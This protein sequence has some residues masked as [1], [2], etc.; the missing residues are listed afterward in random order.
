MIPSPYSR[1]AS[2]PEGA[3]RSRSNSGTRSPRQVNRPVRALSPPSSP[4]GSAGLEPASPRLPLSPKSQAEA[5]AAATAATSPSSMN[6]G[7]KSV[8]NNSLRG[9]ACVGVSN[10]PGRSPN[11]G[12]GQQE[13]DSFSP[14]V[15]EQDLLMSVSNLIDH[16][17]SHPDGKSAKTASTRAASASSSIGSSSVR[18]PNLPLQGSS[19]LALDEETLRNV[20]LF[21]RMLQQS[22][23]DLA[24]E[25]DHILQALSSD[26][27]ST[28]VTSLTMKK[29]TCQALEAYVGVISGRRMGPSP[30]TGLRLST[31]ASPAAGTF[32]GSTSRQIS[33]RSAKSSPAKIQSAR[34]PQ[35]DR[36]PEGATTKA[37]AVVVAP[38]AKS[39]AQSDVFSFLGRFVDAVSGSLTPQ[40]EEPSVPT[41]AKEVSGCVDSAGGHPPAVANQDS[42]IAGFRSVSDDSMERF[43]PSPRSAYGEGVCDAVSEDSMVR[44]H[45]V[46]NDPLILQTDSM[47]HELLVQEDSGVA[48]ARS[49]LSE[50]DEGTA[51]LVQTES[52]MPTSPPRSP[53]GGR[54]AVSSWNSGIGMA[55]SDDELLVPTLSDA[56][57]DQEPSM[58][59]NETEEMYRDKE[60]SVSDRGIVVDDKLAIEVVEVLPAETF[61]SNDL[62]TVALSV[63]GHY[64]DKVAASRDKKTKKLASRQES[65]TIVF[66]DPIQALRFEQQR[67]NDEPEHEP[68]VELCE[69]ISSIE[70][71][72]SQHSTDLSS[73]APAVAAAKAAMEASSTTP[74]RQKVDPPSV[75]TAGSDRSDPPTLRSPRM[76]DV[77]LTHLPRSFEEE[78]APLLKVEVKSPSNESLPA[79][80]FTPRRDPDI[81][82]E[83]PLIDTT[84]ELNPRLRTPTAPSQVDVE[85]E[86]KGDLSP[87]VGPTGDRILAD[88]S[89]IPSWNSPPS[90]ASSIDRGSV[91][92]IFFDKTKTRRKRTKKSTGIAQLPS[93][94][95]NGTG[96]QHVH[97]HVS[98]GIRIPPQPESPISVDGHHDLHRAPP[99]SPVSD[100][101]E[102]DHT[103]AMPHLDVISGSIMGRGAS[104][105]VLEPIAETPTLETSPAPTLSAGTMPDDVPFS[106]SALRN[107][108]GSSEAEASVAEERET[109][110][111]DLAVRGELLEALEH[112]NAQMRDLLSQSDAEETL[113]KLW[114]LIPQPEPKSSKG[115]PK[116][117]ESTKIAFEKFAALIDMTFPFFDGRMPTAV[118]KAHLQVQ[119]RRKQI[120]VVLTNT[121]MDTVFSLSASEAALDILPL[122]QSI[123]DLSASEHSSIRKEAL[124]RRLLR[125]KEAERRR[126][127]MIYSTAVSTEE[128]AVEID[129]A[130]LFQ[131]AMNEYESSSD[132]SVDEPWWKST[133][134]LNEVLERS[135]DSDDLGF[136]ASS[137]REYYDTETDTDNESHAPNVRKAPSVDDEIRGFWKT[138]K[139]R[140]KYYK[141]RHR[142]GLPSVGTASFSANDN[143]GT[144]IS[145]SSVSTNRFDREADEEQWARKR[146]IA[147]WPN[148]PNGGWLSRLTSNTWIRSPEPINAVNAT[149][150]FV[151]PSF[152]RR[153]CNPGT[154]QWN[155]PYEPR[156]AIHKGYFNVNVKSLYDASS[157]YGIQH[158]QDLLPWERRDV[159]QRF[160]QEQSVSYNRNWF[161]TTKKVYGNDRLRQPVCRPKSMEMPMKAG[162][163][164]E[165]WYK[166]PWD[167]LSLAQSL[168]VGDADLKEIAA[169]RKRYGGT[170][171]EEEVSWE[172]TPECGTFRNVKLKIGERVTRVAPD[173]TCSLR[174]SRWRKKFF[175]KGTFPY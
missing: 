1:K 98:Q 168:S 131:F 17:R 48:G 65:P 91:K 146:D 151:L 122:P 13:N 87:S 84:G 12:A 82:K 24:S 35:P 150:Y 110:N 79:E 88:Q 9:G 154:K 103:L 56:D 117:E 174:R 125:L 109:L 64:I 96:V 39:G 49:L 30:E 141:L 22:D 99:T 42:G 70:D 105:S 37:A 147:M 83:P 170:D 57:I 118:E 73:F 69:S 127:V 134:K 20:S 107:E 15:F 40:P 166:K 28:D 102:T 46:Q 148:G 59:Q 171:D 10:H 77:D 18:Q 112:T 93:D 34:P 173:I 155:L 38:V 44:F 47:D 8:A 92:I 68:V 114:N 6:D 116:P 165:E 60:W 153:R 135:R 31:R 121:L 162:E 123:Q 129:L 32:S 51:S 111:G 58:I 25:L 149:V 142:G 108:M 132:E 61:T 115:K 75:T 133:A 71:S 66:D 21:V 50:N 106:V 11:D 41:I 95:A 19:S 157:Q 97:D 36:V 143:D 104:C 78:L 164:T 119:A 67:E 159:K 172:E 23:A 3:R 45:R 152:I 54:Q 81:T 139:P 33:P 94:S 145:N 43:Q 55:R 158:P 100:T 90:V 124:L 27:Q 120:P 2:R 138:R 86:K 85:S 72:D 29:E 163:W 137:S 89:M 169:M 7:L 130:G 74:R 62:D 26:D 140:P 160:L 80:C 76:V 126:D 167:S 175:P 14:H 53:D 128:E 144:S 113:R 5:A 156:I 101:S 16:F 63:L 52:N 161:G 4:R 136:V